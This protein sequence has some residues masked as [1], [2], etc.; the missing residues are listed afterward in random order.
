VRN[1]SQRGYP[2]TPDEAF[3]ASSFDSFIPHD[4]VLRARKNKHT[5]I[6]PLIIGVDPA[7]FGAD[8]TAIAW[9]RGSEIEKTEKRHGLDTMQVAGWIAKIIREEN[10]AKVNIDVGGLGAGIYDRLVEQRYGGSFGSGQLNAVNFGSK[11]IDPPPLDDSGKP[12]GGPA[13]RRAEMWGH[14]KKAL[15]GAHF[16]LP[17]KDSLQSDLTG[18]GYSYTSDGRLL[19]ESKDA[20]KKRGMQSPDEGD[21]MLTLHE[22]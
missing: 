7:R 19:L 20:M 14:L 16:S 13:N 8:S 10:L 4:L 6:G 22:N 12:S 3:L 9:R 5:G 11:P 2:L 1:G 17:D 18:P 15:Q 21:A